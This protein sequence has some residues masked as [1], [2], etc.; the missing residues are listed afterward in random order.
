MNEKWVEETL[1]GILNGTVFP[2]AT[3]EHF[4]V[5]K[6]GNG[7]NV[8]DGEISVDI[9]TITYEQPDHGHIA[10]NPTAILRGMDATAT[11]TADENYHIADVKVDGVS[12]GAVDTYEFENVTEPHTVELIIA[13]NPII[14]VI[15]ATGGTISPET[16]HVEVGGS[17]AFTIACDYQYKLNKLIID[18]VDVARAD[19]YTFTD[20]VENHTI[21]AVYDKATI[22]SF[23]V[24]PANQTSTAAGVWNSGTG[25]SAAIDA[26]TGSAV[27]GFAA[28]DGSDVSTYE[29]RA[30]V[31]CS[32]CPPILVPKNDFDNEIIMSESDWS[33]KADGTSM[34]IDWNTHDLFR[35]MEL[36]YLRITGNSTQYKV[37][38]V[39][40]PMNEADGWFTMHKAG[41]GFTE[42]L[43]L[44]VYPGTTSN[45]KLNSAHVSSAPANTASNDTWYTQATANGPTYNSC[46]WITRVLWNIWHYFVYG[47]LNI[48]NIVKGYISGGSSASSLHANTANI[49]MT[50]G[51]TQG[52]TSTSVD[53]VTLG[54]KDYFGQQWW[55]LGGSTWSAGTMKIQTNQADRAK[56]TSPSAT[57]ETVTGLISATNLSQSYIKEVSID[58]RAFGFPTAVGGSS[59]TYY[60]DAIWS[61][62]GTMQ[63]RAGGGCADGSAC[64]LVAAAVVD[65]VDWSGLW[66]DGARLQAYKPLGA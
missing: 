27:S 36:C 54:I 59:S 29:K 16:C 18:G 60:C 31:Y 32:V 8:A 30:A 53:A 10:V 64:G 26:L 51:I 66:Y 43:Y 7:I 2:K 6:A 46:I 13:E 19:T 62:S 5:V 38:M 17:Q 20:V 15:Q 44:G 65:A 35:G 12:V 37:E 4:G 28:S 61:A 52:G 41:E 40:A 23:V 50:G 1:N 25:G 39:N 63:V 11:F 57:W 14:T 9:F 49:S 24:T 33:K 42:R 22:Y 56:V 3:K 34:T 55:Q 58:K 48:E 47:T 45:S 21:T